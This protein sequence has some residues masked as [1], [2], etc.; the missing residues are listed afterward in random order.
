MYSTSTTTQAGQLHS[1]KGTVAAYPRRP[2][3]LV[4]AA[5]PG[6]TFYNFRES[7]RQTVQ[8]RRAD[9]IRAIAAPDI[10]LSFG[11]DITLDDL[12][13]DNPDSVFWKHLERVVNAPC[14]PRDAI[15]NSQEW[16]CSSASEV[17]SIG[18]S[19]YDP[20]TDVFIVGES[21]NVRRAPGIHQAAV[22]VVSH[23][24]V[25]TDPQGF[26]QLSEAQ[27]QLL[28]T[29]EGWRPIITPKGNRGFVSSRYAF[30]PIGYRAIFKQEGHRWIMAVFVIGD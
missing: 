16:I 12:D 3:R 9:D 30:S 20:Y 6:S 21:V 11:P 25:K 28:E 4:D 2:F 29:N 13:I 8:E 14:S 10:Y 26:E 18:Q 22:D 24:V 27:Q 1:S 19:G 15:D 23:E 7:L 17:E 5:R